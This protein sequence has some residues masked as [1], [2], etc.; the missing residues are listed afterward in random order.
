[1]T[2]LEEIWPVFGLRVEAGPVELSAIGDDDIPILADLASGGIH[3]PCA[4]PFCD[5]V[6][7]RDRPRSRD[8]RI[9]LADAGRVQPKCVEQDL[10]P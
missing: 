6:V 8:G 5:P 10:I 4:M 9:L 2:T 1:M 7:H 3:E